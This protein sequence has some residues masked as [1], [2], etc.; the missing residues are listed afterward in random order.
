MGKEEAERRGGEGERESGEEATE[1][2][3]TTMFC[4]ILTFFTYPHI[5]SPHSQSNAGVENLFDVHV[6]LVEEF[7]LFIG[8]QNDGS[9]VL[10]IH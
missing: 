4:Y 2:P 6:T 1:K 3:N 5:I 8:T 10:F 7:L 9:L